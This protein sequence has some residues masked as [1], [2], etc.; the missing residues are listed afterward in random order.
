M[1][2][3]NLCEILK[4]HQG[5]TFY[6]PL[7]DD[8]VTLKSVSLTRICILTSNLL[9]NVHLDSKGA[10][11]PGG[12]CQL[13]PSKDQRDWNEWDKVNN[14]KTSKTW[15]DI[16]DYIGFNNRN[17][18]CVDVTGNFTRRNTPIERSA[19]ALL[20]I[21]QLIEVGY[22]GNVTNEEW[23]KEI[24]VY[25]IHPGVHNKFYIDYTNLYGNKKHIAFHTKEQAKEFLEYPEN[26]QLLRDYYMI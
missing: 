4:G 3:I 19:L 22:G 10:F 18:Y 5:E 13:F 24:D 11:F 20:K 17:D 12:E 16:E 9:H 1:N 15:S 8:I 25:Y 2:I 7:T 26:V 21:H 14:K 23:H 6:S